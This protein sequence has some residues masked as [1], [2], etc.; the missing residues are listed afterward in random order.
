MR[1]RF[2]KYYQMI[3]LLLILLASTGCARWTTINPYTA[4][5][6]KGQ[7]IR[8]VLDSM[9]FHVEV[10]KFMQPELKGYLVLG[11]PAKVLRLLQKHNVEGVKVLSQQEDR[12]LILLNV[13]S[14]SD[15]QIAKDPQEVATKVANYN[16]PPVPK[17]LLSEGAITLIV[18]GSVAGSV[19]LGA[20]ILY[21]PSSSNRY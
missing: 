6:K 20:I 8:I 1:S 11:D 17:K 3:A 2:S 19:I 9:K 7:H 10:V 14:F 18:L 13:N 12:T 5:L 21:A 15:I 4:S 16:K